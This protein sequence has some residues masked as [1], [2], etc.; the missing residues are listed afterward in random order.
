MAVTFN[1]DSRFL[2]VGDRITAAGRETD[3][4]GTGHGY[5]RIIR[6]FLRA[7]HP[8]IAPIVINRGSARERLPELAASWE[9]EVI[10]E[11]PDLV[12]ILIDLNDPR[13]AMPGGH[14][15][16]SLDQFRTVYRHILSQTAESLPDAKVVL[17]EPAALWSTAPVEAD[18]VL[19]PYVHSLMEIA[20]EFDAK[21]IVPL[22]SAFVYVRKARPDIDWTAAD[23]QPTSS[24]HAVI[25]Y[26]WLEELGIATRSY[27]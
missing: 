20:R 13:P 17:C 10:A 3:S 1:K 26:T 7:K 4:E 16:P 21:A 14:A 5:V 11:R 27:A 15:E 19:R 22:H 25:A 24:G 23:H 2:F 12:S 8:P 6:D 18:E 9:R